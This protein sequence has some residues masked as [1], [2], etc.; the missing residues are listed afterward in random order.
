MRKLGASSYSSTPSPLDFEKVE[1]P[2]REDCPACSLR[3]FEF[4][5]KRI[6]IERLCDGSI[7]VTPPVRMNIDF[8]HLEERL[9]KLGIEP[10]KTSQFI[11]FEDDYLEILIFQGGRMVIRGALKT[12]TRPRTCSPATWVVDVIIVRYG[13]IALKGGKRREF[14]RKLRNNILATLKRKGI[15]GGKA[16]I[17]RGRIL[18]DAPDEAAEI[19][20]KVPPGVVSVSPARVMEYREVPAYLGEALKG[21]NPKSFKVE[22]R[23]LDKT[24]LKTSMEV[25]REIGGLHRRELRVEGRS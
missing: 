23:R 17:V 5:E 16:R 4:L 3:K 2:R 6:K 20:A 14:E 11:Q 12:R 25:N 19:I 21:L 22:T 15:E 24:F 10:L 1:V 8:D 7:Q 18:V 13:E 9:K